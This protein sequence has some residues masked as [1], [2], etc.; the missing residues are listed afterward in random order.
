MRYIREVERCQSPR[1]E[2]LVLVL[3]YAGARIGEIVALDVD[4]VARSAREGIL[5]IV[6]QGVC[7]RTNPL[8]TRSALSGWLHER[9]DWPGAKES[10][11]GIPPDRASRWISA[12]VPRFRPSARQR[13][14]WRSAC[15]GLVGKEFSP[16]VSRPTK[17]SPFG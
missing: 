1:D 16:T 8:P 3:F 5:R 14:R 10:P 13:V 2:P 4:D 12:G 11:G 15:V 17:P 7:Q 6:G 9:G